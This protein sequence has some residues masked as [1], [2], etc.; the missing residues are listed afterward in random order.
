MKALIVAVSLMWAAQADASTQEALNE[1]HLASSSTASF[2]GEIDYSFDSS[3]NRTKALY[4]T[5]LESGD[6]IKRLFTS[7]QVHT[8]VVAYEF[9]GRTNPAIP[10]AV[11][12]TLLSDEYYARPLDAR[13]TLRSPLLIIRIGETEFRYPVA[14]AEMSEAWSE[15]V[16]ERYQLSDAE[17][18]YA[19]VHINPVPIQV[20]VQRRATAWI[21][22]CE[23]LLL[24]NGRVARGT[25]AALAFDMSD[26]VL[27]GLRRF[28]AEMA[29]LASG[30]SQPACTKD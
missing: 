25:V 6:L 29:L 1:R 23:F 19:H 14:I 3:L 26:E 13:P 4:R 18:R 22:I 27:E 12:L 24:V 7:P 20:H 30:P 8:L 2:R 21:P 15:P 17:S 11:G 10:D 5:S 28:A 9:E 16:R